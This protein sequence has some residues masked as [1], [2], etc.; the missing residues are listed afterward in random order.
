MQGNEIRNAAR[1][2][3]LGIVSDLAK[4]LQ[5]GLSKSLANAL[6]GGAA[7]TIGELLSQT[8]S[9]IFSGAASGALGNVAGSA[10]G[11]IGGS[12]AVVGAIGTAATA[13]TTGIS[14][15]IATMATTVSAAITASTTAIVGAITTSS[16][17]EDTLLVGLNAKPSVL[18]TTYA[19]GGIVPSAA[20]GMVVGG[21]GGSLAVLH[22]KE[23]VLPAPISQGIQQMISRGTNGGTNQANLSYSPTINT[24]SRSRGGTGMTRSEF[25]QM[26]S[27]HSGS[28][29][30]EARNMLNRGWRPA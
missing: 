21:T 4:S 1:T 7:N 9:K 30:G 10:A 25:V 22:A 28:M 23:M 16:T 12:S 26:L 15:A 2:M 19:Q 8:F 27:N 6:S 29:M 13:T 17:V 3:F 24:G 20:G 14:T 11:S 18:G 5:E